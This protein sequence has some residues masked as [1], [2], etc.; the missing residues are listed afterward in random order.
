[1]ADN[2]PQPDR[3][4]VGSTV[5][6]TWVTERETKKFRERRQQRDQPAPTRAAS[7]PQTSAFPRPGEGLHELDRIT[8]LGVT[9]PI[10]GLPQGGTVL[11]IDKKKD[12]GSDGSTYVSQGLDADPIKITVLLFRDSRT[13]A[14]WFA[15]WDKIRDRLIARNLSKRNA[16][17]VYHPV[18]HMEGVD[19]LL[20]VRKSFPQ[21][22]SGLF[23]AV[24]LEARDP[25]RVKS[26]G[27]KSKKVEQDR[28][29]VSRRGTAAQQDPANA[30]PVAEAQKGKP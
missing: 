15:E 18:L 20:F 29:L 19:S 13:G 10:D 6:G 16:I 21:R 22:R 7:F 25:R 8:I 4:E 3:G 12:S 30:A 26:G 2:F 11:E 14:D 17:P 9:L 27:G 24:E 23:F 1:M 28:T 5:S